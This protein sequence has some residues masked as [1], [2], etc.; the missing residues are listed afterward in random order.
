MRINCVD[1]FCGAGGLTHGL[2]RSGINVTAGLDLDESC[3]YAFESNN[4]PAKFFAAD[5]ASMDGG[6]LGEMYPRRGL[7][8][9]AGCAPC[10]PFSTY[11]LGKTDS[12]DARWRL[13]TEFGR[14]VGELEPDFVTMENVPKVEHYPVF[15]AFVRRL[16]R[17][18][19]FVQHQIVDCTE[20][21]VPQ[22]RKRLVLLAS[23]LGE[24]HLRTPHP[25]RDRKK[26][27]RTAIGR[28]EK[29]SA[30][31]ASDTDPL[32]RASALSPINMRRLKASVAGGTW[33]DWEPRLIAACHRSKTGGSFPSVYGRMSWELP[34]PTITTQ[35]YGFGNGRF[36]HPEQDRALSLRE[37]AILQTFPAKYRFVDPR[38]PIQFTNVG[39]MVGNAVPVRLGQVIGES[40]VAHA[41]SYQR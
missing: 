22:S 19:Y 17:L 21:G 36:G 10:Q 29:I 33:R 18:G 12:E 41:R 7:R 8:L 6:M 40:L 38:K 32:H 39:L 28:L 37:G 26:S 25:R 15:A 5:V 23:K 11:S 9:L 35:F 30:G 31:G 2:V 20:Y 27:V 4:R 14:L 34:A 3:R 1:L 16:R 24:I 13:L